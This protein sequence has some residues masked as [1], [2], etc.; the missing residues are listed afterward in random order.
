MA[1]VF[2]R[3]AFKIGVRRGMTVQ[4]VQN[5]RTQ[6]WDFVS[7]M[8]KSFQSMEGTGANAEVAGALNITS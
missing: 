2:N 7:T 6:Q 3:N 1:L 8:R 4:F 5:I